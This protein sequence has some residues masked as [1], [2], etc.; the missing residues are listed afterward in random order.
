LTKNEEPS[1]TPTDAPGFFVDKRTHA[2]LNLNLEEKRV[3]ELQVALET[4]KND[5]DELKL[6]I[7]NYMRNSHE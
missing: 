2:V 7:K 6:F 4:T 3:Y 5:V 1:L